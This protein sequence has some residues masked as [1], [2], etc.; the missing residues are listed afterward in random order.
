[1]PE[2][3]AELIVTVASTYFT[4]GRLMRCMSRVNGLKVTAFQS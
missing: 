4:S 1:M 3:V 2:L